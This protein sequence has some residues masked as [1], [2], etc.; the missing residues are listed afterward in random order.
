MTNSLVKYQDLLRMLFQFVC[1][2][3]D[4]G[5]CRTMNMKRDAIESFIKKVLPEKVNHEISWERSLDGKQPERRHSYE[6]RNP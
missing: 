5:I 3:L 4:F 2:D 6:S 1:A